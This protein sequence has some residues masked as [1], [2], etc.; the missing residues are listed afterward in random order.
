MKD[1]RGPLGR[2]VGAVA[3]SL[4][5][6]ARRSQASATTRVVVYDKGGR[7]SLLRPG[8]PEHSAVAGPAERLIATAR[9]GRPRGRLTAADEAPDEV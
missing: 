3:G 5:S 2:T 9:E 6:A 8:T 1:K 4:A 7:P